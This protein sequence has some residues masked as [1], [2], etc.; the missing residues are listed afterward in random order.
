MGPHPA[1][2]DSIQPVFRDLDTDN[3]RKRCLNGKTR[4]P[5][6]SFTSVIWTRLPKIAFVRLDTLK[7]AVHDVVLCCNDGA[8][9]TN[10]V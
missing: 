7:S 1:V 3:L 6:W 8:S 9:K 5:H 2:M 4:N 10:D